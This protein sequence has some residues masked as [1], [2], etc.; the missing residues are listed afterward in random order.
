MST[1]LDRPGARPPADAPGPA[2]S[3]RIL[4][5]PVSGQELV[6]IGVI[7]VLWVVLAFATPAF[8]T[9]GSL[10]PL[11]VATAPVALIGIGMTYAFT[12][13][14]SA[15]AEYETYGKLFK[16]EG[17]KIEGNMFSIGL[18]FNY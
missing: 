15:V 5:S 18:R 7:A 14:L 13:G 12:S 6:L 3:R 17:V 16:E 2:R 4:P 1:T 10:Q 11:L 9:A 8:F